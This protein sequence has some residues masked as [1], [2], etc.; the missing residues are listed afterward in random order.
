MQV[1]ARAVE[2]FGRLGF[3]FGSLIFDRVSGAAD[4]RSRVRYRAAQLRYI[5]VLCVASLL[6]TFKSIAIEGSASDKCH[7]YVVNRQLS[8]LISAS[9]PQSNLSF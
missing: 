3:F 8:S 7:P 9:C 1:T 4:S 6:P 5:H 2:M